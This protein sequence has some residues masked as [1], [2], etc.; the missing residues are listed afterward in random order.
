MFAHLWSRHRWKHELRRLAVVERQLGRITGAR[1]T[2]AF[3]RWPREWQR[4]PWVAGRAEGGPLR[5]VGTHFFFG[6]MELF[7]ERCVGRVCAHVQYEDGE[8]AGGR[9]AEV[10]ANGVLTL[11]AEA[12]WLEG[13]EIALQVSRIW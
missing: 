1:L 9:T 12:G 4:Q 2:L 11:G 3:K 7:G 8:A 13:L 10:A 6:L 5:E